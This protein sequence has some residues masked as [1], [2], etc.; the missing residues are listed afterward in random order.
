MRKI[1][2]Q[3]VRILPAVLLVLLAAQTAGAKNPV[4]TDSHGWAVKGYDVVAYFTL[5]KPT[6]GTDQYTYQW[7]GATWRFAN[8]KDLDAFKLDPQHYAP[9]Y[10]G[11]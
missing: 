9:Q 11:Y 3:I 2:Q 7:Q 5:G 6:K 1:H 10:G 8:S 4:N